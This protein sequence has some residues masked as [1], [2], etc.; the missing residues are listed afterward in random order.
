[1]EKRVLE[2]IRIGYVNNDPAW[3]PDGPSDRKPPGKAYSIT[4]VRH[5]NFKRSDLE[6]FQ[7]Y[8]GNDWE[9][10][11]LTI[12]TPAVAVGL[13]FKHN[14]L[15]GSVPN[16]IHLA[17]F[18]GGAWRKFHRTTIK[19]TR[20]GDRLW[21]SAIQVA[22]QTVGDDWDFRCLAVFIDLAG[23]EESRMLREAIGATPARYYRETPEAGPLTSIYWLEGEQR[24]ARK[25]LGRK[26][27]AGFPVSTMPVRNGQSIIFGNLVG[28][29][30]DKHPL[31]TS[32]DIVAEK[33][34]DMTY[35]EMDIAAALAC[36]DLSSFETMDGRDMGDVLYH[37]RPRPGSI[38]NHLSALVTLGSTEVDGGYMILTTDVWGDWLFGVLKGYE[39]TLELIGGK[40]GY[41]LYGPFF[42]LLD[43][44]EFC[45][46]DVFD[47]T[48]LS[49]EESEGLDL[50]ALSR[51]S[52]Q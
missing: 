9:M 32:E 36:S 18:E 20:Q 21:Y 50:Y 29:G 3:S 27:W 45:L 44:P 13:L 33:G 4:R 16:G 38:A 26:H 42:D 17:K 49:A 1:M 11:M 10:F 47:T 15:L 2:M 39:I 43:N 40:I 31:Y 28:V 35:P 12:Q 25:K 19:W 23:P 41:H 14:S 51:L 34:C 30:W 6:K 24:N 48:N 37:H 8:G 52:I 22:P 46:F 5:N 7:K